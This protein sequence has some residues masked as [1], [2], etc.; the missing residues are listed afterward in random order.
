M[1]KMSKMALYGKC[2][3]K[4]LEKMDPKFLKKYRKNK[5]VN[6]K[7][8]IVSNNCYAGWVYRYFDLPYETPTVGLFIMPADYIKLIYNLKHYFIESS[9][10]FIEPN[11]S[12]YKKEIS[13]KDS[14]FGSYP[15]GLLDDIEIHFLHYKSQEE[16]YSK[17][18]RRLKRFNWNNIVIKFSDQNG[19]TVNDIKKFSE[20]DNY[21]K[22]C[23]VAKKEMCLDENIIYVN[24]FKKDGYMVDDTWFNNKYVDLIKFLNK[25]SKN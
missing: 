24:E 9:L 12:K 16:A 22:I 3:F 23:F 19:C 1:N 6:E 8:S 5:L 14:R 11:K 25:G 13:A 4:L 10:I 18:M 2:K 7:F 21:K 20:L 15:I 17:W